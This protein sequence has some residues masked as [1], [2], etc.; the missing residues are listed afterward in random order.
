[1]NISRKG[2]RVS[3]KGREE[4]FTQRR[5]VSRKGRKVSRKGR[6]VFLCVLCETFAS[7]RETKK[8]HIIMLK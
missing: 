7:L 3:R 6:K 2:R 5:E 4:Y 8:N 1:M